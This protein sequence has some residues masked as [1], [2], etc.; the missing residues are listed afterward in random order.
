MAILDYYKRKSVGVK[1]TVTRVDRGGQRTYI[2]Y[3]LATRQG[4]ES[5]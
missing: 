1:Y 2:R 5:Q 4:Q 3:I